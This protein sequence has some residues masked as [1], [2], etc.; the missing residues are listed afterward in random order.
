VHALQFARAIVEKEHLG[1]A[2]FTLGGYH[3]FPLAEMMVEVVALQ[4]AR[5]VHNK[6]RAI[7]VTL[8]LLGWKGCDPIIVSIGLVLFIVGLGHFPEIL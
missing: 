7:L 4:H 1:M 2:C 5:K 8:L 3:V 6:W